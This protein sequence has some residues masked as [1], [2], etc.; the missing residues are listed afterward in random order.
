MVK[1]RGIRAAAYPVYSSLAPGALD[2]VREDLS[3]VER[4]SRPAAECL[5][6]RRPVRSRCVGARP[7][8][9]QVGAER[10]PGDRDDATPRVTVGRA[11]GG[12]LFEDDVPPSDAGLLLQL[13]VGGGL[14]ILFRVHEAAGER[15]CRG[16]VH[17]HARPEAR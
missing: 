7:W 11:I 15:A 12:E 16:T 10:Q 8:L 17:R 6:D 2:P 1:G 3:M 13:A 5:V 14:E 9:G 4:Q